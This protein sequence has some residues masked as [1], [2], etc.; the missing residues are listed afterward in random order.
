[1]IARRMDLARTLEQAA[2]GDRAALQ[3]LLTDFYPKVREIVHRELERDFRRRH[4]WMLPLFSTGDI[5]QEVFLGVVAGLKEFRVE[6]DTSF[7]RYLATVVKHRLLDAVRF[8]EA[9]RRDQRRQVGEPEQG[10]GSLP[11]AGTDP[12]PSLR[13]SVEEQLGIYRSVLATLPEKQRLLLELRL[14]EQKEFGEIAHA[15]G[16]ASADAARKAF[17]E[18]QAKLLVKLRAKGMKPPGEATL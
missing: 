13:A 6:D 16:I 14:S 8:H 17:H 15:L 10:L 1:M 7:T 2:Q 11:H 3:S 4:R 9:D 5:V 18:A 12:T